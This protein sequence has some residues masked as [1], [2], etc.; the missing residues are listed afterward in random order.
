MEEAFDAMCSDES[1]KTGNCKLPNV[2][3]RA[4]SE[5]EACTK[6]VP[7]TWNEYPSEVEVCCSN[8]DLPIRVSEISFEKPGASSCSKESENNVVKSIERIVGLVDLI[9]R[10]ET[11]W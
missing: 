9:V 11:K 1:E 10:R 7:L 6:S 3:G 8:M 5:A 4:R 2:E